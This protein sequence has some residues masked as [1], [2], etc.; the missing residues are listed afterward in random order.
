MNSGSAWVG[1]G[2]GGRMWGGSVAPAK[3]NPTTTAA[4]L[5]WGPSAGP[6]VMGTDQT[7]DTPKVVARQAEL[8]KPHEV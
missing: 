5:P 2:L 8:A 7:D 6:G 4:W 1:A 3:Q